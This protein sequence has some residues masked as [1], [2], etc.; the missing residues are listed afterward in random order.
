MNPLLKDSDHKFNTIN[1]NDI[2]LGHF[3]PAVN[4]GIKQVR[5]NIDNIK[6]NADSPTF[7]M[8]IVALETTKKL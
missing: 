5:G 4:E 7:R 3:M 6:S 2:K 8:S 1:F